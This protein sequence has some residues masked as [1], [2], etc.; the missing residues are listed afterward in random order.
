MSALISGRDVEAIS[1]YL[2][3]QLNQSERTRLEARLKADP[4][5]RAALE[6]MHRTRAVLR[7]APVLRAPRNYTLKPGMYPAKAEPPRAYPMLRLASVVASLMFLVSFFGDMFRAP[8]PIVAPMAV[9]EVTEAAPAT[10]MQ[11]SAPEEAVEKLAAEAAPAAELAAAPAGT[12]GPELP[13][14]AAEA[15]AESPTPTAQ[16]EESLRGFADEAAREAV[17]PPA[18][19]RNMLRLAQI[20][21]LAIAILTGLAALYLR[22]SASG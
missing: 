20:T 1:A 22:R 12:P 17:Q 6:E 18:L 3:G 4:I 19:E 2:D 21:F 13:M 11:S 8:A 15:P 5:L 16:V 9:A 10:L 7:A 14:A